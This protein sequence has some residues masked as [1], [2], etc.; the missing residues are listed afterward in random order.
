MGL[1]Q[2]RWIYFAFPGITLV[3]VQM[4]NIWL[5]RD[6]AHFSHRCPS[7][8]T[9]ENNILVLLAYHTTINREISWVLSDWTASNDGSSLYQGLIEEHQG[10]QTVQQLAF[11]VTT[12]RSYQQLLLHISNDIAKPT[13][14]SSLADFNA[15]IH[16]ATLTNE[17][18]VFECMT[19]SF[20]RF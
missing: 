19:F 10:P 20:V 6:S 4:L 16:G 18:E 3:L 8:R 11:S 12:L 17:R 1:A 9:P 7:L 2:D 5:I 15:L 13:G 14:R